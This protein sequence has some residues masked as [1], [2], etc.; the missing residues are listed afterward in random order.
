MTTIRA[1]ARDIPESICFYRDRLGFALELYPD[2]D[3]ATLSKRGIRVHLSEGTAEHRPPNAVSGVIPKSRLR[4]EC[5]DLD[6]T[7]RQ[8]RVE[9]VPVRGGIV[10]TDEGRRATVI[11]PSGNPVELYEPVR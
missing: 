5:E 3:A 2:A 9:G 11:D 10:A 8:L 1:V 7:L 6:G 4:V